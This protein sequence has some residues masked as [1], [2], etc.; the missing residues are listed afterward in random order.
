[1]SRAV[2]YHQPM[3]QIMLNLPKIVVMKLRARAAEFGCETVEAFAADVLLREVGED[4]SAWGAPE[5]L[6]FRSEEQ[7]K[8]LLLERL[9]D[10]RPGIELT[11]EFW[12]QLKDRIATRRRN[13]PEMLP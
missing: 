4:L 12:D 6:T 9:N 10:P 7:L 13:P 8:A 5:H 11:P 1:M 2:W 3:P